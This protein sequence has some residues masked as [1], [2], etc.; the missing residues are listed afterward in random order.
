MASASFTHR[1]DPHLRAE[2]ERIARFDDRSAS[3]IANLAIR[4]FVEER[5][6]T[7]ELVAE[8]LR[9]VE[10]GTPSVPAEEVQDWLLADDDRPFPKGRRAP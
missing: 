4:A 2:L 1:M 7:R 5:Q 6:A 9:Q 10:A 8:G 3:Y